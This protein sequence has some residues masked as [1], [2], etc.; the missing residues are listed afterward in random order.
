M[1]WKIKYLKCHSNC[2]GANELTTADLLSV[3]P[4]QTNLNEKNLK[5]FS[6]VFFQENSFETCHLQN[7]NYLLKPALKPLDAICVTIPGCEVFVK[8]EELH[9]ATARK[10]FIHQNQPVAQYM[11]NI[12]SCML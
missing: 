8:L 5:Q 3:L 4:F 12:Q 6:K 2:T 9:I 7:E 10:P 1:I 11:H